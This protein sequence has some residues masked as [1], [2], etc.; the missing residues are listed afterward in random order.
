[1]TVA[2]L[3]LPP[4]LR[5]ARVFGGTGSRIEVSGQVAD[6]GAGGGTFLVG[7]AATDGQLARYRFA[8]TGRF[9]ATTWTPDVVRIS[10]GVGASGT[11]FARVALAGR[12]I[13]I[14]PRDDTA[15]GSDFETATQDPDKMAPYAGQATVQVR[16]GRLELRASNRIVE[17]NLQRTGALID[18]QGLVLG[19]L[20]VDRLAIGGAEPDRV[21]LYGQLDDRLSGLLPPPPPGALVGGILPAFLLRFAPAAGAAVPYKPAHPAAYTFNTCPF[22]GGGCLGVPSPISTPPGADSVPPIASPDDIGEVADP[23]TPIDEEPVTN[24]GGEVI[25]NAPD[26][27]DDHRDQPK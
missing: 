25:W 23:Y 3:A 13:Y 7:A 10:G 4:A 20:T 11:P 16:A 6:S 5:T 15:L 12:S 27:D 22:G 19:A 9:V 14:A 26:R 8:G 1:V 18:G 17:R 24:G 21:A 2:D